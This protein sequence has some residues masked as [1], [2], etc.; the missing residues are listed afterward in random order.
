MM[1]VVVRYQSILLRELPEFATNEVDRLNQVGLLAITPWR[2]V[3]QSHNPNAEPDDVALTI[4]RDGER[5]VGYLGSMA[6]VLQRDDGPHRVQFV[7]AVLS[8]PA[9]RGEGIGRGLLD[10]TFKQPTDYVLTGVTYAAERLYRRY[11][12]PTLPTYT[13]YRMDVAALRIGRLLGR[14]PIIGPRVSPR[15]RRL[16][17]LPSNLYR[18]LVERVIAPLDARDLRAVPVHKL[19]TAAGRFRDQRVST[20]AFR[21]DTTTI[22]WM[23]AYPWILP[24]R[25]ADPRVCAAYYFSSARDEFAFHTF[26]LYSGDAVAG[27]FVISV[28]RDAGFATL[29]LL[30]YELIHN[31]TE[32]T[33]LALTLR[34]ALERHV[35]QLVLPGELVVRAGAPAL[36][37]LGHRDDRRG[38]CRPANLM[39]PLVGA[40]MP[41]ITM[42]ACDSDLAFT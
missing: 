38:Y 5:V 4:A 29:K 21:R 42:S 41:A 40:H 3:A 1:R 12:L 26:E 24:R 36:R 15:L 39:G 9:R 23:L 8:D 22:H 20:N 33:L 14:I 10:A 34:E 18:R 25:D 13:S 35:D 7:S 6:G 30:D 32:A 28:S 27:F 11:G 17:F 37:A 19:S 2:A 16:E 31:V